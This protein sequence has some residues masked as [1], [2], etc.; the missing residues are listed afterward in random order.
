MVKVTKTILQCRHDWSG[1]SFINHRVTSR[2]WDDL[3]AGMHAIMQ[4]PGPSL[5]G[6]GPGRR[7]MV[8]TLRQKAPS[9]FLILIK[10]DSQMWRC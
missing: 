3:G 9:L 2:L 1:R 5:G 10:P 4:V 8:F 6:R 7:L